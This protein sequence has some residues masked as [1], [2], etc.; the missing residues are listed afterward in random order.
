VWALPFLTVLAPSK[1]ANEAAG[2]RHKTTVDWTLQMVKAISR[3]LLWAQNSVGSMK[4]LPFLAAFRAT[5]LGD[6]EF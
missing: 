4:L 2:R 6:G 3:W 5:A 1:R